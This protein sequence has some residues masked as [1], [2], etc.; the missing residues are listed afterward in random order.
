DDDPSVTDTHVQ[1]LWFWSVRLRR[2]PVLL[3]PVLVAQLP[4]EDLPSILPR[5][6]RHE[7][8]AAWA[9]EVGQVVP[10][11]RQELGGQLVAARDPV[12]R[13]HDGLDRLP[14]LLVRHADGGDVAHR[15][16]LQEYRVDL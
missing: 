9:F 12:G 5:Q 16:V 13:L 3:R 4:L 10:A 15:R 14:P 6:L 11:E 2:R 8:D 7:V 1:L